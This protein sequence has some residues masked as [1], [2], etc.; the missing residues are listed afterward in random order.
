MAKKSKLNLINDNLTWSADR[1]YKVNS[2]AS[3]NGED[4]QNITG[5]NSSPDLLIDWQK[6]ESITV[7]QTIIDGSTNAVS[8]NA[9]Y[10]GLNA[11]AK[12]ER[13]ISKVEINNTVPFR[14]FGDSYTEGYDASD[15]TKTSFAQIIKTTLG[16]TNYLN[17]GTSG[18]GSIY[19][20]SVNNNIIPSVNKNYVASVMVGFNDI[21]TQGTDPRILKQ[22]G[23]SYR[24]ILANHFLSSAVAGNNVAI[25][26]SGAWSDVTSTTFGGKAVNLSGLAKTTNSIGATATY[27]FTGDNLVIGTKATDETILLDSFTVTIDGVNKGTFN[28][29]NQRVFFNDEP[30]PLSGHEA[31]SVV[32]FNDIGSGAHTVVITK[33]SNAS[34]SLVIDYIGIMASPFGTNPIVI[35]DIPIMNDT[36]INNAFVEHGAVVN[37]DFIQQCN[38]VIYNEIL[39]FQGY[40][41]AYCQ[42]NLFF[43]PFDN[44]I[45][46][47]GTHPNDKGHQRIAE[48]ILAQ[49]SPAYKL[50]E[51]QT[52]A[53]NPLL[54]GSV[55]ISGG[56]EV[57]LSNISRVS[58]PDANTLLKFGVH[59]LSNIQSGSTN[60]PLA[61]A[62]GGIRYVRSDSSAFSHF[63]FWK[64]NSVTD[65][66]YFRTGSG[67][68]TFNPWKIVASTSDLLVKANLSGNNTFTGNQTF[69]GDITANTLKLTGYTVA[70]LPTGS[71]GMTAYVTNALSPVS[72]AAVVGGGAVVVRVFYNGVTWI[73]Q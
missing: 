19:T 4:Y 30:A 72:L 68:S 12:R 20:A 7:D 1:R 2:V 18:V 52:L 39:S 28:F 43:D 42:T 32:K 59:G 8:G 67:T 45:A 17:S 55:S 47:D 35:S 61:Q 13:I 44:Q 27:S 51:S 10:D 69:S 26:Y 64:E 22:I 71:I 34:A 54:S 40:P 3:L 49:L 25:T 23:N 62:G 24:S 48:A 53:T 73:V 36:T 38:D 9:V 66:L 33:G 58:L 56:N 11:K 70:T 46:V 50:I 14:F 63:E 6:S 16:L 21:F 15:R 57:I 29:N 5:K 37:R 60:Y 41:I 31:M 65:A